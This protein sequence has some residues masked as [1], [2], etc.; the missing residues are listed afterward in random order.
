MDTKSNSLKNNRDTSSAN[1][2]GQIVTQNGP[3]LTDRE[4]F[5]EC[6]DCTLSGLEE[7]PKV[8]KKNDF[9]LCH[10]IFGAYIRNSLQKEKYLSTLPKVVNQNNIRTLVEQAEKV[11]RHIMTPCGISHEFGK[12]PVDWFANPTFNQYK[13]WT[14]QLNR[15]A[16]LLTLAKAYQETKDER[17]AKECCNLFVSWVKQATRP[18]LD[19]PTGQSLCWR[20]IEAGIRMS[21]VWPE[22]LHLIFESPACND[23]VLTDWYKSVYEHAILLRNHHREEGN[24]VIMEM[25][26]LAHI[27]VVYPCLQG[28]N[29][30]GDYAIER[31]QIELDKQIYPDGFQYEL[32]TG[33]QQI[34][35]IHYS[36][37]IRLYKAYNRYVPQQFANRIREMMKLYI[38]LMRPSGE[39]PD[40]NDGSHSSVASCISLYADLFLGEQSLEWVASEG[41]K[42]SP[43]KEK[44]VILP[45]SGFAVFRTGWTKRDTW[46]CFDCGP[47]GRAHQHEDKLNLLLHANG[48]YVLVEG[49]NYAYDTSEMR[50]Y[51]RST[52]AHNTI[53][54]DGSGQN[55]R[56][57]Y[58]WSSEQIKK[59][60]DMQTKLS[61]YVDAARGMYN[62][63]YGDLQDKTVKH[64]RSVYFIKGEKV[65]LPF[66]VVADRLLSVEGTHT[67]EVQWHLDVEQLTRNGLNIIA[68]DLRIFVPDE[69]D[70]N[71]RLTVEYGQKEPEWNGW[72]ADSV[73]QEDYRPVYVAKHILQGKNVRWIT[74]LYP[75]DKR[76]ENPIAGISASTDIEHTS[77]VVRLTNGKA[78][79]FDENDLL[80][81]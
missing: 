11:M 1:V 6:L 55:R 46:L 8:L 78:L 16:E 61:D 37:I 32:S 18:P 48:K 45:Y 13:E 33:Y 43:P 27:S 31:L 76:Q 42:G 79:S 38:K 69:T 67:Y 15:H 23:S 51:V 47:F 49:N 71:V 74:L 10:K 26:G 3:L 56:K 19:E 68:D 28:S 2:N 12:K 30:W 50:A 59:C 73:I 53:L 81:R 41:K 25:S 75:S 5:S 66:I 62:D 24:W 17:Y 21:L 63:G 77:F 36:K 54:V 4:F 44:S 14:W 70:K 72:T 29:E 39:L 22:I 80:E 40:L 60:S 58:F 34:N 35:I 65:L 20:T 7:I 52:R 64:E 9:A 57:G